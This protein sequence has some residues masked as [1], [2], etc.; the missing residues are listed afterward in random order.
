M[1]SL[2]RAAA[3]ALATAPLASVAVADLWQWTDAAGVVRYTPDPGRVPDG[4]RGTL[5]KVEPGMVMP[6]PMA[7]SPSGAA[8][9]TETPPGLY[10]PEDEISFEADPFNAPGQ[11][12]NLEVRDVPE[13]QTQPQP[14]T[15]TTPEPAVAESQ[16]VASAPAPPSASSPPESPPN[17]APLSPG[18]LSRRAELEAQIARDEETLKDLISRAEAEGDEP[19]QSSPELREVAARLPALQAELRALEGSEAQQEGRAAATP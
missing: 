12:R 18:Q 15:A 3:L 8:A 6:P 7:A 14:Q 11:A 2:L 19:L 17:A 16:A 1:R 4:R 5:L 10:A 13:P 9:P